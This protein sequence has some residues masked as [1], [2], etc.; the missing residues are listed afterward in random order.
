MS[1]NE[2]TPDSPPGFLRQ[3]GQFLGRLLPA[4]FRADVPVVPVVRLSGVIGGSSPLRPG[5]TL[6]STARTLERAFSVRR[7][8]AVA[9]VI[10]SPG[11]SPTQSHL[12]FNRI[13]QLSAEK[14]IPVLAFIEDVGASGG[15]MIACAADEIICDHYSIVG[16]IGVVGGSFGFPKLLDKIG[17]ERRIY[18]SGERKVMLDPF[19]P[20]NPEDV[21]RIKALQ[22]DM[23]DH[24]IA[25]VKERRAAKLKGPDETLFSGEFWIA[26]A[27]IELGLADRLGD[28]RSTLRARFGDKVKTPV[29]A[30][31]KG[32]FARRMPGLSVIEQLGDRQGLAEDLISAV[33]AR[34]HWSRYGL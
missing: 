34:A 16:S 23:H 3:I 8:R 20:E 12:I 1:I 29:I 31:A 10:N 5:M 24:F 32:F 19:S 6:A 15:Y 21:K 7:A 27:A 33:E 4:R 22:K 30:P 9:L 25:L 14:K 28:L 17:V 26:D 13:R 2:A 11:G 18:T